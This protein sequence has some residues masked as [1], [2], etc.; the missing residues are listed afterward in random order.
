MDEKDRNFLADHLAQLDPH[1]A[2]LHANLV[3]S[4][5]ALV[6]AFHPDDLRQA[7]TETSLAYRRR[8]EQEETKDAV[9]PRLPAFPR[10][11]GGLKVWCVYCDRWHFHGTGYGHRNA[12][13]PRPGDVGSEN[14][15][16][17]P[18]RNTGYTLFDPATVT[19]GW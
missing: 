19:E 9:T 10:S 16:P 17:S 8:A 12:H 1:A 3:D 14:V 6:N 2:L 18:Y 13:C 4:T 7:L 15:R 11:V 5:L